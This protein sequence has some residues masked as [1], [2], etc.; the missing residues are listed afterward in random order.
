M[1]ILNLVYEASGIVLLCLLPITIAIC[2]MTPEKTS[3]GT[4]TNVIQYWTSQTYYCEN[5][6]PAYCK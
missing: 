4:Y 1:K 5:F 2:I 6:N 3:H